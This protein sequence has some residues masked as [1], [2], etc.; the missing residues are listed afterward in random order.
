MTLALSNGVPV[1]RGGHI[2]C[3]REAQCP[4]NWSWHRKLEVLHDLY[5]GRWHRNSSS[6]SRGLVVFSRPIVESR[7]PW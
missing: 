5:E 6:R 2:G 1:R 4:F 7:R 3:W